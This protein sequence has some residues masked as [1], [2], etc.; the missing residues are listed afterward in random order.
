MDIGVDMEI[1]TLEMNA[2]TQY[3]MTAKHEAMAGPEPNG[4][5]RTAMPWFTL[6]GYSSLFINPSTIKDPV[7]DNMCNKVL[8]Q[9]NP[10]KFKQQIKD[11]DRYMVEHHYSIM[12]A[13]KTS[14][15]T[16]WQPNLKGYSGE[17]L[18]N[19]GYLGYYARWW[20]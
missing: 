2:Y 3:I 8:D 6:L 10:A 20:K 4:T 11:A 19:S 16:I 15:F 9:T 7:Y 13:P 18:G 17:N 12:V 1:K 14:T 5:A